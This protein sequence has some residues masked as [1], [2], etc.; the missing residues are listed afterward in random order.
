MVPTANQQS[1]SPICAP[2]INGR[3]RRKCH[4]PNL[5]STDFISSE[6]SVCEASQ[7]A[8]AATSENI[9]WRPV[10]AMSQGSSRDFVPAFA[11][12]SVPLL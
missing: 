11:S 8:V 4:S 7:F 1:W 9:G 6:L 12:L 10:F 2:A 3:V 5:I